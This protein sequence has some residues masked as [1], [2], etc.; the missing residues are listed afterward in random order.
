MQ[1]KSLC[2]TNF[3]H[4]VHSTSDCYRPEK[5]RE[6]VALSGQL[7][8][9]SKSFLA[10]GAGLSYNDCCINDGGDIIDTRRLN[11][12]LA[13]DE[14][15]EELVCQPAVTFKDLFLVHPD[16]VPPV[17]P[18]TLH[19]TL[20]GGIANDVHG[21]NNHQAGT[22]GQHIVWI[23]LL[24]GKRLLRISREEHSELFYS[25]IGGLGLTGLIKR[26]SIKLHRAS[27]FVTVRS[28]K[29]QS[30]EGLLQSMQDKAG[31]YR[32]HAAWMDL[33]GQNRAILYLANHEENA[34]RSNE[35]NTQQ[36]SIPAL[37]F[38]LIHRW[39]MA[40][41]NR[42]FFQAHSTK[43][44]IDSL[45]HFNNPLDAILNWNNL[46]GKQ[47]LLQFQAVLPETVFLR[48]LNAS[49][50]LIEKLGAVPTLA[51]LKLFSKRGA[52]LLSFVEPGF[53]IAI[54]FI[55]NDKAKAAISEMNAHVTEL[56]GRV[57]LAKDLLLTREQFL[58]QYPNYPQFADVIKQAPSS[59]Q[60]SLSRRL[61][62]GEGRP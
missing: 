15:T 21:K 9:D 41:F 42:F 57:Y 43:D 45:A 48:F 20:A 36:H 28:E 26:L 52:G 60:S 11:H 40:L 29:H 61:G 3:S 49:L 24:Q 31:Q 1:K 58:I 19:A 54:D 62:L 56:G 38:R 10:R 55:N 35:I 30:W 32:Y 53:S 23:D 44:K 39:N 6:L 13:F 33:L 4:S 59:L 37:P 46:Y 18:G 7:G 2:L 16:Y 12:L 34:D 47:G 50:S 17:I 14:K 51:V 8:R 5:E 22:L 27:R 25:T